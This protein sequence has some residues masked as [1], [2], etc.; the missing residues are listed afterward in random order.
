MFY[1]VR[2]LQKTGDWHIVLFCPQLF[3]SITIPSPSPLPLHV[4][5][6]TP[7]TLTRISPT[8]CTKGSPQYYLIVQSDAK[9]GYGISAEVRLKG[10]ALWMTGRMGGTH[11]ELSINCKN[12]I[13]SFYLL[14]VDRLTA[15]FRRK[16]CCIYNCCLSFRKF[17]LPPIQAKM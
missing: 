16:L 11:N 1:R 5:S 14:L 17:I 6:V 3:P 15:S 12:F 13:F 8:V 10:D 4:P 2:E 9:E 7:V